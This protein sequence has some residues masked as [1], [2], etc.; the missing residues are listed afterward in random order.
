MVSLYPITRSELRKT[1]ANTRE[2][3]NCLFNALSDQLYGNQ[4][5]HREIRLKTVAWMRENK[6][7]YTPF[8]DVLPGGATRRNP[9]RKTTKSSSFDS[10]G[11]TPEEVDRAF[12]DRLRRMAQGGTYGDNMEISAFT[13]AY[14]VD[15]IIVQSDSS[16]YISGPPSECRRRICCIAYHVCSIILKGSPTKS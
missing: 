5:H 16:Y 4:G 11:P 8:L 12:E 9:K 2:T 3:G 10:A 14:M 15:V 6:H 7:Q 1:R 13:S